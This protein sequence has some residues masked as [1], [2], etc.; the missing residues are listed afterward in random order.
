[1]TIPFKYLTTAAKILFLVAPLSG[2]SLAA[3]RIPG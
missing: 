1:M 3:K 2:G